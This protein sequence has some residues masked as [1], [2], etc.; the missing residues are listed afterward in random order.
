LSRW[1]SEVRVETAFPWLIG[2]CQGPPC[3]SR[4]EE[5]PSNVAAQDDFE[6]ASQVVRHLTQDSGQ[7]EPPHVGCYGRNGEA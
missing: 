6:L 5:A 1:F 4:R 2:V 3:S 7:F